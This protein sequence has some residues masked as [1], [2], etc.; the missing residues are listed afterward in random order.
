MYLKLLRREYVS[1]EECMNKIPMISHIIKLEMSMKVMLT[2]W[3][4]CFEN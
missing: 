2:V 1:N 3:Y 4:T